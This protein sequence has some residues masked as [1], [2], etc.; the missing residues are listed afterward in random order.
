MKGVINPYGVVRDPVTNDAINPR[1]EMIQR[2]G[3]AYWESHKKN[4]RKQGIPIIEMENT[5]KV[6]RFFGKH[7][8]NY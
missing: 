4:S 5:G 8:S 6:N 3:E 7:K 1:E 2:E